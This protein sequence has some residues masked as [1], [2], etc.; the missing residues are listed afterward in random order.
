MTPRLFNLFFSLRRNHELSAL[1][2]REVYTSW[3]LS[4]MTLCFRETKRGRESKRGREREKEVLW[5]IS[6]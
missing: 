3:F 4:T 5:V 2:D 6:H 1:Q